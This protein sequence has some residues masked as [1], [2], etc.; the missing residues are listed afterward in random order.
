LQRRRVKVGVHLEVLTRMLHRLAAQ[1][2]IDDAHRFV[3]A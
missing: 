2:A 3:G 1:D